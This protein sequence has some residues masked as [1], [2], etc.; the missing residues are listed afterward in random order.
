[1]AGQP[2]SSFSIDDRIV[3]CSDQRMGHFPWLPMLEYLPLSFTLERDGFEM[4]LTAIQI[5]DMP[6]SA[7][8][9]TVPKEY[10]MMSK[11]ELQE[12]FGE[13]DTQYSKE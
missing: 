12:L 9:F 8:Y 4:E 11:G 5:E 10:H 2:C 3:F 13:F 7:S 1:V 6:I